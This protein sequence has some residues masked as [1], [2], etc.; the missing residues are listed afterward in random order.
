MNYFLSKP[1]AVLTFRATNL[2]MYSSCIV[3]DSLKL[4][5][6]ISFIANL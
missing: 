2:F 6:L 5:T 4:L 1:I 3:A